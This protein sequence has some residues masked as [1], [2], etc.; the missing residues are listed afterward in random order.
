MPEC[1]DRELGSLLLA[2][3]LG[4]L[5]TAE[6]ERFETH[7]LQCDYCFDELMS[8]RQESA[9]LSSDSEVRSVT[10]A[11][12]NRQ[13]GSESLLV[14]IRRS[15]WPHTSFI[16]KPAVAY[17]LI[18][19]LLIP[20]YRGLIRQP[21]SEI[22]EITQTLELAP[23]RDTSIGTFVKGVGG[24]VL[25]TFEFQWAETGEAHHVTI[26][27]EHG[28]SI[29]ENREFRDFDWTRR[30]RLHLHLPDIEP[31]TYRLM[32]RGQRPDSSTASQEYFF[33]VEE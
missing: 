32:I 11:S 4:A 7:L 8:F 28:T 14:R 3:E 16:L 23:K 12:S 24:M 21:G 30:G 31:G 1:T 15:L 5:P 9:L 27:S 10:E 13:T 19:L 26:E 20:A 22:G 33:R 2:Y 6:V 17:I 18:L 25:L 29:Y